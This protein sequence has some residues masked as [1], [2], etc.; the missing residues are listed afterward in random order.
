MNPNRMLLR[1][2]IAGQIFCLFFLIF[3]PVLLRLLDGALGKILYAVLSVSAIALALAL[4]Y[5]FISL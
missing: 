4:R 3:L 2:L 1:L 5:A